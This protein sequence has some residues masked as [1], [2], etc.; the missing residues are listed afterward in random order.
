MVTAGCTR[1]V[2][3]VTGRAGGGGSSLPAAPAVAD[4]PAVAGGVAAGAGA[5]GVGGVG[6]T[7]C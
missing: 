5:G 2:A 3:G 4:N 1:P 6:R 7:G